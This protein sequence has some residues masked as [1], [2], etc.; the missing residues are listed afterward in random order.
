MTMRTLTAKQRVAAEAQA[1]ARAAGISL[2]EYARTNGLVVRELYDAIAALRRRGAL[3]GASR[4]RPRSGRD[5]FLPVRVVNT[6]TIAM[7]TVPRGGPVCRL[8]DAGAMALECAEWPPVEW[9]NAVW[10]ARR[11]AAS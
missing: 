5:R 1:A 6:P 10:G 4:P 11:D 7:P 8:M 9:L 3:S 2:V